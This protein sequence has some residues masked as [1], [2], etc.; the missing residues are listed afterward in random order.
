MLWRCLRDVRH[1]CYIDVGAAE[2]DVDSVTR[3]FYERG[4]S[5]INVE[6]S[7]TYFPRLAAER[8][9]DV[10]LRMA[11]GEAPGECV[12]YLVLGRGPASTDATGLSTLDR[13]LAARHRAAGFAVKETRVIV[14]TLRDVCRQHVSGEIHFLKID[15]EGAERD[16]LLGADFAIWRP[17]IVLLEATLPNSP[18]PSHEAWETLLLEARY[19]FVWFDGLNRF[20]LAEEQFARLSRHFQVPPNVFDE[21]RRFTRATLNRRRDMLADIEALHAQADR[22]AALARTVLWRY[23]SRARGEGDLEGCAQLLRLGCNRYPAE[24]DSQG[25]PLFAKELIRTVL[26][27]GQFA[28]ADRLIAAL[29]PEAADDPWPLALVARARAAQGNL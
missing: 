14:S 12:F 4:W 1:G 28:E 3:A 29:P 9:R 16:V 27:Q 22:A 7:E 20:Y 25:H 2:P 15:V 19:R 26:Q 11:L 24:R 21:F 18:E 10:N 13:E 23:A 17:W 6:P 8:Q 5:G